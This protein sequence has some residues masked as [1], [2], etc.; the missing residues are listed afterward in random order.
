MRV[1]LLGPCHHVYMQG[2]GLSK[3]KTYQTPLGNIELDRNVISELLSSNK[4]NTTD[5]DTEED[6]HSLEMHL[7]FI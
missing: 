6:E 2:A 1:F 5:K 4:F 3:L 7:P